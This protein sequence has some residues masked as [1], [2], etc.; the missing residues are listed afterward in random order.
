MNDT[1]RHKISQLPNQ[2][3]VYLMRDA[4]RTVLYVGKAKILRNRVRTYFGDIHDAHPRTQTMVSQVVDFD[5][6]VV[7]SE[8]EALTLESTLIKRYKPKYNVLLRDDKSYPYIK[9]TTQDTFPKIAVVRGAHQLLDGSRY[10]G[11][12]TNV[13]AMWDVVRLVRRVFKVRQETKNSSKRHAGCT[14]DEHGALMKRPCL[15]YDIRQCSGPC[16]QL[17]TREEYDEQV[18]QVLLFL[19]GRMDHL[20]GELT[21]EMEAAASELRFEAAARV[22]DK[23][24]SLQQIQQDAEL[25]SA[26]HEDMDV[27]AYAARADDACITVAIV[28]GGK[29][30]D[31]QHYLLDGMTGVEGDEL[32]SAFVSQRYGEMGSPPR[33]LL[34]PHPVS[35]QELLADWLSAH[36]RQRVRLLVPRRGPKADVVAMTAENARIYLEQEQSKASEEA[37]KAREA[38]RELAEILGLSEPPKRLECYDI[39][40]L[41]GEDAVGSMV[42]FTDGLPDKA[43]YRRFKIRHYTGAPDDYAMMREMLERRLGAALMKS[44]KFSVLPDLMVI[45]GGKGQLGIAVKAMAELNL[46]R[47]VIGLAK[48][49][50]EI[51]R[52]G[53]E[54]GLML[55]KYSRALHLLQCVRDEAHRFALKYHTIL[56]SRRVR[57]SVLDE[58]PGVGPSRKQALLQELGSLERIR[59]ASVDE[60]AKVP[61]ISR[62]RAESILAALRQ[63]PADA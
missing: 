52:P 28:R 25:V 6:I 57:E 37:S 8:M 47:P 59:K 10:F 46:Q 42:V 19:E 7:G 16:A 56:R 43:Q 18:K 15:D 11:P 54:H 44:R 62:A 17:V 29:L 22:R 55:P 20:I 21:A 35:G 26:K 60:L 33:L 40:T 48:R 9:I 38:L 23:L 13:S 5:I 61:G 51:F 30:V 24:F 32:L 31:Q 27:I 1:L 49:Y 53:Q 50:E 4:A 2:P 45:D 12:Y 14:W 58:I 41:Q 34:L 63:I 3:G 39:S 36:R